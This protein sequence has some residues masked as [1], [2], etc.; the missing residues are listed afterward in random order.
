MASRE[1]HIL[2]E[3]ENS[4]LRG[5]CG[6][7]RNEIIGSWQT[8][9]NEELHNL[10]SSSNITRMI[11]PRRMGLRGNVAH[12]GKRGIHPGFQWERIET[13]RKTGISWRMILKWI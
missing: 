4:E 5:I 12:M 8:L 11:K 3:F 10:H 1:E 7:K 6:L 13:T 2:R 9:H